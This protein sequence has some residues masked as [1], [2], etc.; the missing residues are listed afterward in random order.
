MKITF[1]GTSSGL[2]SLNQFHSSLLLSAKSYNLLI[3][4][5]D[6]ISRALLSSNLNFNSID[7]IVITHL[8][9][10]HFSGFPGL[11]VQMKL[12]NRRKPLDIFILK[13]LKNIVEESLLRSYLFP[14]RIKFNLNYVTFNDAEPKSVT[15]NFSFIARKNSHLDKY[16]KYSADHKTTSLYCASFS[17]EV[18]CKKI[19]YTSDIGSEKDILLFQDQPLEI[20]ICEANHIEPAKIIEALGKINTRKIFLTHYSDNDFTKLSEILSTINNSAS[21]RIQFAK[22]GF[23]LKI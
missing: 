11:I 2:T 8:H 14:E 21:S 18:E 13:S 6:G 5:G 7:G 23:S 22:D 12:I 3:D 9:P 4:A 20:F 19:I 17:F 16:Q 15:D 10:D 1:V